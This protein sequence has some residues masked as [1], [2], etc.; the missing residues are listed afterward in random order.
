MRFGTAIALWT[1][2]ALAAASASNGAVAG[3]TDAAASTPT[4][5]AATAAPDEPRSSA[6]PHRRT[7]SSRQVIDET[8]RSLTRD[9]TLDPDQQLR[10]R[11]LLLEEHRQLREAAT[12][13]PANADRVGRIKAVLDQTRERIRG[14]LTP[15][16]Q[17][18]YP[19]VTPS[20]L[21]GPAHA[22]VEGW[23]RATQRKPP[24]PP[25]DSSKP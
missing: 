2:T 21:L 3:S 16:Q 17:Q 24:V 12:S 14:I 22:D 20:D 9:L 19:G 15:E 10:L 1:V 8:V 11:K 23:I 5:T 18:R 6:S 4:P 25:A 13:G 7:R